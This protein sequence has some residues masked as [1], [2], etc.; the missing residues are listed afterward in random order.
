MT[1]I[2]RPTAPKPVAAPKPP[3]A[4]Q[5]AAEVVKTVVGWLPKPGQQKTVS[6]N[7]FLPISQKE[8]D[9]ARASKDPAKIAGALHGLANDRS[10]VLLNNDATRVDRT[11]SL[12][13]GLSATQLD[14]VRAS[15]IKQFGCDP[16]TQIR[17]G[18]LAQPLL[19]LDKAVA[20]E[21]VG[22]LNAPQM[23]QDAAAI[24]GLLDKANKGTLTPQDRKDYFAMLPRM[25]LWDA[26]ARK[27]AD[28]HDMD[29]M[30]RTLL[31]RAWKEQGTGGLDAALKKIEGAMPAAV[32]EPTA[33]REKSIAVIVSSK[34]AQ[35][36]EL[37]DWAKPLHDKG[38][39]IQLFTPE[40]RPVAFQRDSLSVSTRTTNL[41]YGAPASLDPKGRTGDIARELLGETAGAAKFDAK[42]YG[43]VYLAGGLGFNEDVAVAKGEQLPNG[44]SHSVLTANANIEKMMNAAV[45][46]RLPVIAL[47]HGPT[48]LAATNIT[49]NGKTEKLAKGIETASLP[50]FEGYV[51]F[52]G[53][54]EEQF[55][56]DVN[57]HDALREAG[58]E[59]H[60]VRDIANMNRVVKAHKDGMDIITG[61]GPQTAAELADA[62]IEAMNK[63]WGQPTR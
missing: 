56:Y 43:A 63:R 49:V 10:N 1:T 29:S 37:M 40:G 36:Q 28:G 30:E 8:I 42:Q 35:W 51:G 41:G 45:A 31:N 44:K 7:A 18:D 47:C 33:P 24:A 19:R 60:V 62:T 21:M 38:Y 52:T 59:T 25:G 54:K 15:Y 9:S 27:A 11:R 55:T 14:A 53:R 22:A 20:L 16:E 2:K 6:G 58:A 34:G 50:P 39:D 48:L 17:S 23:K 12:L 46:E 61:P 13:T 32:L 57:T 5:K 4:A 3:A 26:P